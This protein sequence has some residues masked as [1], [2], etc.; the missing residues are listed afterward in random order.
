MAFEIASELVVP[1]T[2]GQKVLY[3]RD[4]NHKWSSK[5]GL[6]STSCLSENAY[7][8]L[9][10]LLLTY[11][12]L[13]SAIERTQEKAQP[14]QESLTMSGNGVP[15]DGVRTAL[16]LLCKEIVAS[17]GDQK[18]GTQGLLVADEFGT[19]LPEFM[20]STFSKC[21][22]INEVKGPFYVVVKDGH[23]EILDLVSVPKLSIDDR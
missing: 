14:L 18:W 23:E 16:D 20:I 9:T 15:E 1:S 3:S 17:C 19:P 11:E 8:T 7:A 2:P 5:P 4:P 10:A 13:V 12:P 6:F 22:K 21:L